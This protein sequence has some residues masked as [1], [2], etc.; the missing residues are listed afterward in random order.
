MVPRASVTAALLFCL[1]V[2]I[3]AA[4]LADPI[5]EGLS[6]AG[7]F[8]PGVFTDHSNA[9]VAP[10][11]CIGGVFAALF[12]IGT[13]LLR[14]AGVPP[15]WLR[16]CGA[17][18]PATA[19]V[20][21][22]PLIL[23]MQIGVLFGMETLEQLAVLGHTLGGTVWLGGPVLVAL[24]F[25]TATALIVAMTFSRVLH[26]LAQSVID[27]VVF[28]RRLVLAWAALTPAAPDPIFGEPPCRSDEPALARL[29]GRGPP[30]PIL[31]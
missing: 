5:V 30:H 9:A 12:V 2:A 20:R 14:L 13:A 29:Q 21:L 17:A 18:L 3:T 7:A 23:V 1:A 28:F 24:A 22:F 26:R 27:A 25:H 15:R 10:A 11:L 19:I 16:R 31:S 6:N 4:A 8:G